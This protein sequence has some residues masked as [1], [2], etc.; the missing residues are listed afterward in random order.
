MNLW[1]DIFRIKLY[2]YV[3]IAVI[4]QYNWQEMLLLETNVPMKKIVWVVFLN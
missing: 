2:C 4:Q 1:C 3:K